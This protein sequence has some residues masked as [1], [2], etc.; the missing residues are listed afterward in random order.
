MAIQRKAKTS[1]IS[2]PSAMQM[3]VATVIQAPAQAPVGKVPN[4]DISK[5]LKAAITA[6]APAAKRLA[7]ALGKLDPAKLPGGAASDLLYDLRQVVKQVGG[8][9]SALDEV[10]KP[11]VAM[12]EEHFVQTLAADESSGLQG[13]RSR[14]QVT[15]NPVPVIKPEDWNKFYAYVAKTKQWEL[16]QHKV[17][18]EAVRDRWNEKRQVK[19]VGVF[20]VKKVSCTKLGGK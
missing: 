6:L 8:V 14:T 15:D 12:L 9:T 19:F 3:K 2:K 1:L 16:L 18:T 7:T 4:V 20:H 13:T 17:N 5:E 10:V 11:A